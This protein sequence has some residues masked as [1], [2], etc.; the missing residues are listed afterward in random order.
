MRRSW[1]HY[2]RTALFVP[3][4]G[5]AWFLPRPAQRLLA[6]VTA[7]FVY[8]L[9]PR[10]R[11]RLEKNQ[12]RARGRE[13][14][15]AELRTAV[16]AVLTNY[17]HYLLDF[18]ALQRGRR[19]DLLRACRGADELVGVA[20]KKRGAILVTAHLG[21]WEMAAL[22][23]AD[24]ARSMTLVSAP[25]EIG[26]LGELRST[27]RSRQRHDELLVGSD[28]MAAL[29]LLARLR[30]G[31]M[32]GMQLDRATGGA[33]AS[34]PFC[35]ARLKMPRG[36]ARLA[37]ASEAPI[38][39]VFALFG[40]G[41]GYELVV[42]EPIDPTGLSE[43]EIT[44]RLAAVLERQVRAHPDQ[45]LM[46]QDPWEDDAGPAEVAEPAPMAVRIAP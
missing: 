31:G 39:P 17:G 40:E 38:V 30:E 20:A 11:R 13:L 24:R 45:W 21:S 28:P 37:H 16:L 42:E 4:L 44:A 14:A 2:L 35:G 18:L 36:P 29:A 33:H 8:V 34:V 10:L 25:E 5:T 27:I 6:R 12:R 22:F 26:Y 23:L 43:R 32:V 3:V 46:M 15:P 7:R 9:A 19:N 41:D 1:H